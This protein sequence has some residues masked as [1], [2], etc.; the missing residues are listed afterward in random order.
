MS[1]TERERLITHIVQL[2]TSKSNGKL[3]MTLG[4][5]INYLINNRA[6]SLSQDEIGEILKDIEEELSISNSI[7][8]EF[9]IR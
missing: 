4:S 6:R 8:D 5:A 2:S 9:K 1:L 3:E 7:Y